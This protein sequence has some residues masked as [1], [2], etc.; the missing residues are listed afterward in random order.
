MRVVIDV[1]ANDLDNPKEIWVIVCKDIDTGKF[2]VF[3]EV[4]QNENVRKDF[5]RF[6]ENVSLCIGHNLLGYDIPVLDRL[7]NCNYEHSFHSIDTL[8]ISKMAD[9]SKVGHSIADYGL[10][11]NYPKDK[12][13]DFSKYSQE[14]E[15][16]CVRDVE[17]C[18][19]IYNKY[20]NYINNPSH[21]SAIDTEHRFQLVVNDLHQNGFAFNVSK[22]NSL[23]DKVQT[24]LVGLDEQILKAFP[25][26]LKPVRVITP[27]ATKFDTISLSSIPKALRDTVHQLSV[28]EPFTYCAWQEFNPASHKQIVEVLNQSGWKPIDK[29]QTHIDTEREINRLKFQRRDKELDLALDLLYAK[30]LELEKTG[31]KV[32]ENNLGTLPVSAPAPAKLLAKRI[33]LESRRRTLTEWLGLVDTDG[34]IHGKFYGIGAWTHRMAHQAPNTANIPNPKN[35]DGSVKLLG[36]ELRSLWIAP[37]NRLLV[38]CDAE[39]IQLRVFAHYIDDPEFTKALVEG[40]SENGSDP[41]T[42]NQRIL[43]E[44]CK[45]REASKRFIY[46]LLLGAGLD[47]L[48]A[49]L[50]CSRESASDAL[51]RIMERYQGFTELKGT[52]IPRDAKRGYFTAL[53]GRPIKIPGETVGERKHLCMSGYLQS[54]EVIIMKRATLLFYPELKK[55]DSKLVNFVHDEWQSETPNDMSI[56]LTIAEAKA[57]ALTQTGID[58][59]LKC[60]LSGSYYNVKAKDYTIGTNWSV[61]H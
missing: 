3:K 19:R 52:T 24:D 14:M 50:E 33:L 40:K 58:L 60:P 43:G 23:L 45:T 2:H 21:R 5:I 48:A 32:N 47:K 49:I 28:D 27:K 42:L 54:G 41:H 25:P 13:V 15:D 29:T 53:D 8:I 12:F 17:I 31:W 4:T 7:L 11:F 1:E 10:E 55:L 56:A 61:T 51:G 57:N 38:G 20:L 9:Y 37:K 16:Y 18:H 30:K 44:V 36:K 34:R 26:K 39:G 46:A 35:L 22:A 6:M 59:G